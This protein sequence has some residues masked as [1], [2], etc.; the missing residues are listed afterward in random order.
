MLAHLALLFVLPQVAVD[1]ALKDVENPKKKKQEEPAPKPHK[2][3]LLRRPFDW[4]VQF[5]PD[6]DLYRTYLADPRQSKSGSKVQFPIKGGEDDNIKIENVLGG[7][8]PLVGWTDGQHPDVEMQLLVEAAVFSRFDIQ[9][10]WDMDAADY[11]F[12]FP[13]LYRTGDV[14]LKVHPYHITSHMGDEY[15]S[16]V[17]GSHR[18]SYHLD[19]IA[20]GV[21]F[22]AAAM[23]RVYAEIGYG[24]YTGPETD[25]GRAQ[26]GAEYLLDP[27]S[28]RIAPFIAVDLQTRNEIDWNWNASIMAGLMMIPKTGLGTGHGLRATLEYYR[29]SDSQTQ[30][31]E[32]REHFIAIGFAADF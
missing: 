4:D 12:G 14:I 28:E 25:A 10:G 1:A 9:E 5:A 6:N 24:F 30:F 7:H 16:R 13:F 29:G 11:R 19:E 31:K 20:I 17:E 3:D 21:S 18:K 27:I 15:L 8:R 26:I 22:P 2:D 32:E 23:W